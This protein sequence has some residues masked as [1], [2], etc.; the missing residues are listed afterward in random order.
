MGLGRR[1]LRFTGLFELPS[2]AYP[3]LPVSPE[4]LLDC[5]FGCL[6]EPSNWLFDWFVGWVLL[7]ET[8]SPLT[9]AGLELPT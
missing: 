5:N 4:T 9:Q 6:S 7:F 1:K 8:V 3:T 2:T